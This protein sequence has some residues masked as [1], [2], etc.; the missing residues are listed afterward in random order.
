MEKVNTNIAAAVTNAVPVAAQNTSASGDYWPLIIGAVVVGAIFAFLWQKGYL[1]KI[2][3]YIEETKE[4]LRKCTWPSVEELK[5][6]TLVVIITI[7]ILGAFT[8]GI[9]FVLLRFIRLITS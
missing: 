4:E 8:V 5:G 7:F 1:L 2:R 6:S 3:S 9:D